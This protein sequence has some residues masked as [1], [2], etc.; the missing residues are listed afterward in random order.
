MNIQDKIADFL[1][2]LGSYEQMEAS[3][4]QVDNSN[5]I[6]NVDI[7]GSKRIYMPLKQSSFVCRVSDMS[8]QDYMLLKTLNIPEI[9]VDWNMSAETAFFPVPSVSVSQLSLSAY[10]SIRMTDKLSQYYQSQFSS[11][12]LFTEVSYRDFIISILVPN[13]DTML[14]VSPVVQGITSFFPQKSVEQTLESQNAEFVSNNAVMDIMQF[15]KCTL[16][17]L[18]IKADPSSNEFTT[19]TT[20]ISYKGFEL[21]I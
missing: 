13:E 6:P 8:V 4:F 9:G 19:V 7:G 10:T 2:S 3:D 1:S 17:K 14:F 15:K 20:N 5:Y 16:S 12:L 18:S 11:G 21:L